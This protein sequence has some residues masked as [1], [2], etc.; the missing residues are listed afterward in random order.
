MRPGLELVGFRYET[1]QPLSRD[2]TG[3]FC[4]PVWCVSYSSHS[5]IGEPIVIVVDI[6]GRIRSTNCDAFTDLIGL[7]DEQRIQ[8]M[9][10]MVEA[11][12]DTH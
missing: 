4:G 3:R 5:V 2:L 1:L 7:S 9:S 8:K 12:R 10:K 6:F 11:A